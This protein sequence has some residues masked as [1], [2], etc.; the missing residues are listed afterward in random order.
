ML[1]I[2]ATQTASIQEAMGVE[3][4]RKPRRKRIGTDRRMEKSLFVA[5]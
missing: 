2:F 4:D 1:G 3:A 5:F